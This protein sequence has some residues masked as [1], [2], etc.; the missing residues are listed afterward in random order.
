L[1]KTKTD[2]VYKHE[3]G[4]YTRPLVSVDRKVLGNRHKPNGIVTFLKRENEQFP[5]IGFALL[6]EFEKN[7]YTIEAS[8]KH[9][10]GINNSNKYENVVAITLPDNQS[11]EINKGLDL[12]EKVAFQNP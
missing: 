9:L 10:Q 8:E 6:P 3:N 11:N 12:N 2:N 1:Q 5:D 4:S 7:G